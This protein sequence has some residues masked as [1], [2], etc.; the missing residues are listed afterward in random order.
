MSVD[1]RLLGAVLMIGTMVLTLGL[2]QGSGSSFWQGQAILLGIFVILT[3]SLNL[4]SGFTGLFSLGQIGFMALGVYI[5]AILTLSIEKKAA[6]L[7]ELPGWLAGVHLDQMIGSLPLGWLA[8]TIIAGI[9]VSLI[10]L[11]VG[12]VIMRL[13]GNFVAVAT[14]GFLV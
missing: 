13:S 2:L 9:L 10:A 8:A 6:L 11:A 5:S 7:P 1:R 14:L 12:V 4:I 3:V